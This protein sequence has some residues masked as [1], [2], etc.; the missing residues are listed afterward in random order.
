MTLWH[1]IKLK[2]MISVKTQIGFLLGENGFYKL[3][4]KALIATWLT[5]GEMWLVFFLAT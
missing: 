4:Y 3:F 2:Q 1:P 5:I